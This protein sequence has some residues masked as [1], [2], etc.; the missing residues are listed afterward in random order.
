MLRTM[1]GFGP[2][3][4]SKAHQSF[5]PTNSP[6]LDDEDRFWDSSGT[7]NVDTGELP[8][9]ICGARGFEINR[10]SGRSY[11]TIEL[12]EGHE[13]ESDK[14]ELNIYLQSKLNDYCE[15]LHISVQ[16]ADT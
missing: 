13:F 9:A 4:G 6:S 5:G 10:L 15:V 8:R 16:H 7:S 12:F 3:N 2:K 1:G 11:V 14:A